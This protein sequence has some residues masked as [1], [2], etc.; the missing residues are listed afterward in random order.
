[1]N[2]PS[3]AEHPVARPHQIVWRQHHEPVEPGARR[4]LWSGAPRQAPKRACRTSDV[5][6]PRAVSRCCSAFCS[7][8]LVRPAGLGASGWCEGAGGAN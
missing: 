4:F 8:S 2:L 5:S 6:S 3:A 7:R 1:L